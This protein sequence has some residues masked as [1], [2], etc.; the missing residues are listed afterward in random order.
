MNEADRNK[1]ISQLIS[2]IVE[3]VIEPEENDHIEYFLF[4]SYT[5]LVN[6]I[7]INEHSSIIG[8]LLGKCIPQINRFFLLKTK[9]F[10]PATDG[11]FFLKFRSGYKF[12]LDSQNDEFYIMLT[13]FEGYG[14]FDKMI[15]DWYNRQYRGVVYDDMS[16]FF[17]PKGIPMDHYWW[18]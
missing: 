1:L 3:S 14:E 13:S 12:L 10:I 8:F 6:E 5:L 15:Y 4:N 2:R 7:S 18:I 17:R 16:I 9:T 11:I